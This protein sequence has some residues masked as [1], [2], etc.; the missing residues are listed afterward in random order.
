[1]GKVY[2]F[3]RNLCGQVDKKYGKIKN[4]IYII[5]KLRLSENR[6]LKILFG[7]KREKVA[8]GWRRLH[9]EELHNLY[10]SL[11]FI[12]V[13]KSWRVRWAGHVALVGEI[14][15]SSS[16]SSSSSSLSSFKD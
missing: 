11:N 14:R 1:L 16:S 2:C 10:T 12:R 13:I 15:S 9:N 3:K 4:C 8:G 5:I 6:V 7:F